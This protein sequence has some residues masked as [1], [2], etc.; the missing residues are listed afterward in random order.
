MK[1]LL[2]S[3]GSNKLSDKYF[4]DCIKHDTSPTSLHED[5]DILCCWLYVKVLI[6]Y[7]VLFKNRRKEYR[8][9][10][11]IITIFIK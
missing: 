2:I 5:G 9:I 3:Y 8:P 11:L 6:C 1:Q 4:A 7:L 10:G